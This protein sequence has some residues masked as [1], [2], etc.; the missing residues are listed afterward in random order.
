VVVLLHQSIER[1]A[2]RWPNKLAFRSGGEGINFTELDLKTNSLANLL[3]EQGVKKGD[4][5][6]VYLPRCLDISVAVYGILKAGAVYVP[7]DPFSPATRI[8]SLL[9]E[10]DVGVV[11]TNKQQRRRLPELLAK[12]SPLRLVIGYDGEGSVK[13]LPSEV[14]NLAPASAPETKTILEDDLAYIITTS[15]STGAPKGV[16]HTHRSGLAYTKMMIEA[17]QVTADDVVGNH[18]ALHFD[19]STLAFF[20]GP[21]TGATIVIT[22]DAQVRM[23]VSMATMIAAEK[24]TIW[25]SVPLALQQMYLSDTMGQ[26]DFSALRLVIYGGEPIVVSYLRA[27]ME[28]LPGVM[29]TNHYGPAEVNGCVSYNITEPPAENHPIPIGFAHA[30]TEVLVVDEN[31]QRVAPN[32]PGLLLTRCA[33]MMRGYWKKPELTEKSFYRRMRIPGFVETFYRTGDLVRMDNNGLLHF[34]GRQDR[35]IKIRGYR[36]E[37]DEIENVANMAPFIEESAV[38]ASPKGLEERKIFLLVVLVTGQAESE[39][40]LSGYLRKRLPEYT[41]PESILYI[42]ALPRTT[43]GKIDR[44]QIDRNYLKKINT[45]GNGK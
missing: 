30:N 8:A 36:V 17:Y 37:L 43:G 34:L 16:M 14:I 22:T 33:S 12:P 31:D 41:L 25:Y 3:L 24:I 4:R 7:L 42:D 32:A 29:F 5:V 40:D 26:L 11:V 9:R 15:G 39:L 28:M 6:G 20:A 23:P 45:T 10:F 38:F 1:A 27:L 35:Q 2:K 13:C 21:L 44:V 18:S 19:M